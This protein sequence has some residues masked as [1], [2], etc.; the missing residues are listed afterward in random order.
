MHL[1]PLSCVSSGMCPT[2]GMLLKTV[3]KAND[4][5]NRDFIRITSVY[6]KKNP[7][8]ITVKGSDRNTQCFG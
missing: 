6:E 3:D 8:C 7:Y 5:S 2:A 1:N 4:K